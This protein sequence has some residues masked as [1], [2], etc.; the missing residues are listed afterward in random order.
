MQKEI[1][2]DSGTGPPINNIQD[3]T[4]TVVDRQNTVEL[5]GFLNR[6]DDTSLYIA[7]PQGTWVISREDILYV[8]DWDADGTPLYMR[9]AGRPV[10]VGIR[11]GCNIHEIRPWRIIKSGGGIFGGPDFRKAIEKIFTLGGA[12]SAN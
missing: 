7:D 1:K 6:E 10:R 11:D 8:V 4:H 12:D 3:L 9:S 5:A 2:H